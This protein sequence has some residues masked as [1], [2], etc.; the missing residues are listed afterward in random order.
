MAKADL[1]KLIKS[2]HGKV[3]GLV[4]RQMPDG[5][6]NVSAAPKKKRRSSKAQKAYRHGTF[7]DRA[8][9]ARMA[10]HKYPIYAELAADLPMITAYNLALQDISYPPVIHSIVRR[11][12]RILVDAS[13][14]VSVDKVEVEIRDEQ[15]Q[16]LEAGVAVR[17]KGDRWE[18]TAKVK[19]GRV[20]A[21]AYD[22][23]GNS[24]RME[25]K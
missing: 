18:Y 2:L 24:A 17:R 4:F 21:W 7:T 11:G 1:S 12:S 14:E 16:L 20:I 23:P 22:I 19:G 10:Q 15:D 8:S 5:S 25:L 3:G 6:Y 9:W 13:D